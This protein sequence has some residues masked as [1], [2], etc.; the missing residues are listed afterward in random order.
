M[1]L[2]FLFFFLKKTSSFC[3]ENE[4]FKNKKTKKKDQF[5]TLEKAKIGP[6]FNSTIYIYI[7]TQHQGGHPFLGWLPR[8]KSIYTN[9]VVR[10]AFRVKGGIWGL[11]L[12][13]SNPWNPT[14]NKCL[15][16]G[17]LALVIGF[18]Q[19]SL[20]VHKILVRKIWF[21]PPP[22]PEKGPKWGKTDFRGGG[23]ANRNFM[24]K[25][26]YG[27]LGVSDFSQ[28]QFWGL[29]NTIFKGISEP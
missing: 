6:A 27:H 20:G 19:K 14:E 8:G 10:R 18:Y 1:G 16:G 7:Y 25:T 15:D 28:S 24:D 26:I 21:P 3:T 23:G 9:Q 22:P 12:E 17:N 29:R 5:L 4:I 2:C 13:G 11:D